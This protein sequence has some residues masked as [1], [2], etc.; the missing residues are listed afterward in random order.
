VKGKIKISVLIA[1]SSLTNQA[2]DAELDEKRL[3]DWLPIEVVFKNP[4]PGC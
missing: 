2:G 1:K 4:H 3:S